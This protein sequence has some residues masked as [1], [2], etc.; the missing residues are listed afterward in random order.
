MTRHRGEKDIKPMGKKSKKPRSIV[1][2]QWV[3]AKCIWVW[4]QPKTKRQKG[5]ALGLQEESSGKS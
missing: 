5:L 4:T 1:R 2:L 3:R